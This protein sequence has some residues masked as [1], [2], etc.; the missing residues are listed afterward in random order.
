VP[1]A[2]TDQPNLSCSFVVYCYWPS[3]LTRFQFWNQ[4]Q[5]VMI[6]EGLPSSIR[7]VVLPVEADCHL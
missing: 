3:V 2:S 7:V 4:L 6:F 1:V 5:W